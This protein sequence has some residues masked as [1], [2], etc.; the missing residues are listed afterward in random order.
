MRGETD[1]TLFD[2]KGINLFWKCSKDPIIQKSDIKNSE[3][4]L[5][6]KS[7]FGLDKVKCEKMGTSIIS[8]Y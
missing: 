2:E 8:S 6:Y 4:C 7:Y 3:Y 1:F 5:K